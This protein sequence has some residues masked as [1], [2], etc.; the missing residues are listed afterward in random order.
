MILMQLDWLHKEK[1]EQKTHA[2]LT[3]AVLWRCQGALRTFRMLLG[4]ELSRVFY[5]IYFYFVTKVLL[6]SDNVAMGFLLY[7]MWLLGSCYAVRMWLWVS[8]VFYVV[9]REL[10]GSEN[11]ATGFLGHSMWY[12]VVA[13]QSECWYGVSGYSMQLLRWSKRF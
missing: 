6:C 5:F 8:S 1:R 3:T 10:L 9:T 11:V 2:E 7:F 12:Y 13:I 4:W